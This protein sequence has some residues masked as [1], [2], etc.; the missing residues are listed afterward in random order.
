[1][2]GVQG[3]SATTT[4]KK[5]STTR[6]RCGRWKRRSELQQETAAAAAAVWVEENSDSVRRRE[7]KALH[8]QV[9]NIG[10]EERSKRWNVWWKRQ[11]TSVEYEYGG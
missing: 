1:M 10:R 3:G 11:Q 7:R 4:A 2:C 8:S 5:W 6:Y 9:V